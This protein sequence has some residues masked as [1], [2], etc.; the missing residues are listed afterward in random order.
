MCCTPAST[1][2]PPA[3]GPACTSLTV[4][5]W[6]QSR[7]MS[8]LGHGCRGV[9]GNSPPQLTVLVAGSLSAFVYQHSITP[10][11]LPCKL[12]IPTRG[13]RRDRREAPSG[14]W[15]RSCRGEG[16]EPPRCL[17]GAAPLAA[18]GAGTCRA[19][20]GMGQW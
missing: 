3:P 10:L 6:L 19:D 7:N 20:L 17:R 1:G 2:T 15:A 4:R 8:S 5:P 9:P 16:S 18:G 12:S 13:R 11:A 14:R